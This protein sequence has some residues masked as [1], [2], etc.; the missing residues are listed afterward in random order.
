MTHF[1]LT[2]AMKKR[3]YSPAEA[4]FLNAFLAMLYETLNANEW[5]TVAETLQISQ[6]SLTTTLQPRYNAPH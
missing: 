3:V 4:S 5:F 1:S 2:V 6:A